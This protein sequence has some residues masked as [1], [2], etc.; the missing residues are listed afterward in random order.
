MALTELLQAIAADAKG[1]KQP[2]GRLAWRLAGVAWVCLACVVL[3][4]LN[5]GAMAVAHVPI[6]APRLSSRQLLANVGA[7]VA[8][9]MS[10]QPPASPR[11][12]QMI[13]AGQPLGAQVDLESHPITTSPCK[14]NSSARERHR[15]SKQRLA[16]SAT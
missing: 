16:R 10:V 15:R 13:K 3:T 14:D 8:D 7:S 4:L 1:H 5:G 11:H 6:V 12:E 9:P 2:R